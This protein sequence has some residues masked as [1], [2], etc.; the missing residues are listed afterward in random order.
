M[1][2]KAIVKFNKKKTC[3]LKYNCG[4]YDYGIVLL[5]T[6][7]GPPH[8]WEIFQN[9]GWPK[10]TNKVAFLKNQ[11]RRFFVTGFDLDKSPSLIIGLWYECSKIYDFLGSLARRGPPPL[12]I[13]PNQF[14]PKIKNAIQTIGREYVIE[15]INL[16]KWAKKK[17]WKKGVSIYHIFEDK[18]IDRFFCPK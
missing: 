6:N 17:K 4:I 18:Q 9:S 7:S 15:F 5:L 16:H 13:G 14:W 8:N 10:I 11:K 12:L 2:L 3:N 1:E